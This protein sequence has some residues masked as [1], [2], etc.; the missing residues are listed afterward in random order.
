MYHE[1]FYS[2]SLQYLSLL[3]NEGAK[4]L[5]SDVPVSERPFFVSSTHSLQRYLNDW[6]KVILQHLWKKGQKWNLG[7][8]WMQYTHQ[9]HQYLLR[10]PC[11][12]TAHHRQ[13][14]S[15]KCFRKFVE[16][17]PGFTEKK[18]CFSICTTICYWTYYRVKWIRTAPFQNNF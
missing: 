9:K 2:Y 12:V 6:P 14:F 1:I 4:C 7:R 13:K 17:M 3:Q 5:L 16:T 10:S 11:G 18:N 15:W 8:T